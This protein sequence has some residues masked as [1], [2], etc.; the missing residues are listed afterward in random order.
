MNTTYIMLFLVTLISSLILTRVAKSIA[1]LFDFTA[2]LGTRKIHTEPVAYLGG[3]AIFLAIL[4][5]FLALGRLNEFLD[6]LGLGFLALMLGL[7]DDAYD[8]PGTFKIICLLLLGALLGVYIDRIRLSPVFI[9]GVYSYYVEIAATMFWVLFMVSAMNA[10][11]NMDGL[12]PGLTFIAGFSFFVISGYQH[13]Q[14]QMALISIV[15]VGSTVGFLP[16]NFHPAVIFLGDSGSFF[17]GY[18]LSALAVLGNWSN[19]PIKSFTLP[20]II[21]SVPLLDLI[22]TVLYRLFIG[23]TD[24]IIDS[25]EY[26]ARDHLSHRIQQSRNFGQRR[27]VLIIYMLGFIF[28]VIGII[29]RNAYPFEAIMALVTAIA[30]YALMILIILPDYRRI[31]DRWR[32]NRAGD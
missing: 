14:P 10:I 19:D 11:D 20:L 4:I 3:P 28:G 15:I 6:F 23:V 7:I 21:L 22:F 27:T 24:G 12:A 8:L 2:D 5:G 30:V 17:L 16:Y 25:I 29:I 31:M 32:S 13:Q 1:Q 26:S 18:S 9:F